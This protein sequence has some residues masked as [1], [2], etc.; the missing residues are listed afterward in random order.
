MAIAP[1]PAPSRTRLAAGFA[2][3][4][5]IW[6]S[7]YLAIRFGVESLPPFLMAATRFA[8]PGTVLYVWFR[9]RGARRPT[10]AQWRATAVSGALLLLGGNGLVTWAEQW[11]PSGLTALII[12]SVPLW[13]AAMSWVVEP[14]VRPGLRGIAGILLG[15]GGIA[16][17]VE[18]GGDLGG[19]P[20]TM[21]GALVIVLASA[22]WAAGSLT[23][24]HLP[25]PDNAFLASSMQML[26]GAAALVVAGT[27]SGEWTRIDLAA[28][29]A[30]SFVALLYLM[31]FGSVIALSA[32][33][34][35]MKVSTPAKASTYAY[36]N[37]VVAVFLGWAI[38]SEPVTSRTVTAAVVIVAAVV[39]ITTE[40][41]AA[42]GG[43][44]EPPA[45]SPAAAVAGAALR[46]ETG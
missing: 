35:L 21:V 6:G 7:T 11:V 46:G 37:P 22:L 19:D 16:F 10:G 41:R 36:V 29:S 31:V 24:R 45:G 15:F 33:V 18:P 28:V 42:P 9:R 40:R 32:Y 17:L 34:W 3:V 1:S 43:T 2:A 12:A 23:S 44:P 4:Y 30:R 8:V 38:A 5:L 27:I 13:M 14:G 26:G 39:M 20:H 25:R